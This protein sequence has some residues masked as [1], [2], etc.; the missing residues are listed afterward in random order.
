MSNIMNDYFFGVFV[1]AIYNPVMA[2]TYT[3]QLFRASQLD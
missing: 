2:N 1:D 3:I